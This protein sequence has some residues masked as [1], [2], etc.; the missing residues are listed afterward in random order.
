MPFLPKVGLGI[1]PSSMEL[2]KSCSTVERCCKV[3]VRSDEPGG[4][5]GSGGGDVEW[6]G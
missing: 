2:Q 1:V 6:M 5:G 4:T 3:V